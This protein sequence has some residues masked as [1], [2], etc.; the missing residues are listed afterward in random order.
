VRFGRRGASAEFFDA[1]GKSLRD[2]FLRAPLAFR[3]VSSRFGMRQHPILGVWKM[4][5]GT[6]YAAAEG[7]PV[8]VVGDGV[9]LFAGRKG[10]YGNVLEVRHSNGYVSRYGHLR[11]FASGVRRGTRVSIGRTVAYV[12]TTGLSTAPH[13]HFEMLLGG[14]QRDPGAALR[15]AEAGIIPRAERGSFEAMRSRLLGRVADGGARRAGADG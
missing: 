4:H 1:A 14:A 10:G 2:T 3:R 8:R 5:A 15:R 7:T 12:G 6:D 11:G 9:V 13:L